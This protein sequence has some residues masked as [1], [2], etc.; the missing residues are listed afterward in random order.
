MSGAIAIKAANGQTVTLGDFRAAGAGAVTSWGEPIRVVDPGIPL[1]NYRPGEIDP[2]QIWRTQP[3]VRKVV[4]FAARHFAAV[5]W[6]AHRRVGDNDRPRL[7]NSPA[8]KI[9]NAP[10]PFR[11]GYSFWETAMIDYLL[12]DRWCVMF[13]QATQPD[14]RDT[15]VRIPPKL[16]RVESNAIGVV[17]RVIMTNP[18]AGEQD[19]DLTNA[20]IAIGWGW[21]DGAAGGTSPMQTLSA[22]LRENKLAV[23]WRAEQW[24]N[25]PKING[26]LKH[27]GQFKAN[28]N[29]TRFL[30]DW[31][32][33]KRNTGG[34][35]LLENGMEYQQLN[36][37]NPKDARD[38]EGRALSDIEV[39]SA[40]WIPP[41]LV[42][43]REGNFSNI[44]A[45]RNMLYGPVLGP[46][47]AHFHQAVNELV[48]FLDAGRNVYVEQNTQD[49][50]QGSPLEQAQLLST[51]TGRPVLT[52]NEAR[53]RLNLPAVEGGDELVTPMNVTEG[54]QA[55]PRDSGDQNRTSDNP[56][57]RET[58][59][60]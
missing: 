28:E 22:I 11:S 50:I 19:V 21:S 16:L 36:S 20:P 54:G 57:E 45:Y 18:Q 47:F 55:S 59:E 27:P 2:M 60:P 46:Y 42:G 37:I 13:W 48:P 49:A 30:Q 29:R 4:G 41:E 5:P 1:L 53:A 14:E 23:E 8:E 56:D 15:L 52:T 10:A 40:Y 44:A 58:P 32:D 12:Y 39:A 9:M 7:S 26:L 31:S 3:S 25:G 51:L 35:P 17:K 24:E 34:T 6:H 43:A 38:I 33:W